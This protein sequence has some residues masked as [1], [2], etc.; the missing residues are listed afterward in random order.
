MA[1]KNAD[2]SFYPEEFRQI[3]WLYLD[4]FPHKPG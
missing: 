3:T 4:K 2:A 1:L